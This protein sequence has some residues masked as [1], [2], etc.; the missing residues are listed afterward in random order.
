[1]RFGSVQIKYRLKLH[2]SKIFI[3][4]NMQNLVFITLALF[5]FAS[6]TKPDH[7]IRFK[8]NFTQVV[9]SIAIGDA[10][11][12]NIQIG[13]VTE[14]KSIDKGPF[15]VDGRT[16]SGIISGS[17]KIYGRGKHNWTVTLDASSK[18]GLKEDK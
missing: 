18:L 14:Y 1:M 15:S 10:T 16:S 2:W 13:T 7:K 6:C 12:T 5:F 3:V 8:N 9:T 17:G 11:Y 4:E